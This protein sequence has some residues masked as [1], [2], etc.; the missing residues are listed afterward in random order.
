MRT[1]KA[2]ISLRIRTVWSEPSLSANRITGHHRMYQWRANAR[3]NIC[4]CVRWLNLCILRMLEDTFS[5]SA[6][7]ISGKMRTRTLGRLSRK[8]HNGEHPHPCG[9]ISLC[10]P[11]EEGLET[12]THWT[13][14]ETSDRS[15]WVSRLIY[16][17]CERMT[18]GKVSHYADAQ[19]KSIKV[20]H[21][22]KNALKNE[23]QSLGFIETLHTTA[24]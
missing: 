3:M 1:V 22:T 11:P 5:L 20:A 24:M 17:R 4:S 9:L 21:E 16:F 10:W 6:A 7:H 14:S 12:T 8:D 23:N 2:Q 13:T 15:V 18:N 19:I